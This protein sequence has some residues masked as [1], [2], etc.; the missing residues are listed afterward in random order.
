[1]E[2]YTF[3]LRTA[4]RNLATL[5]A[6]GKLS[7]LVEHHAVECRHRGL[8]VTDNQ[9]RDPDADFAAKIVARAASTLFGIPVGQCEAVARDELRLH[10]RR[11]V[12]LELIREYIGDDEVKRT[13]SAKLDREW[14]R[15]RWAG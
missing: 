4:I 8:P 15:K 13:T 10:P 5:D 2:S 7:E 6:R 12:A 3:D 9:L 1:M 14:R 11:N